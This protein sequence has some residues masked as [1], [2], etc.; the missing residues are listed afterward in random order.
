MNSHAGETVQV[1]VEQIKMVKIPQILSQNTCTASV[2]WELEISETSFHRGI[3]KQ[4]TINQ[5]GPLNERPFLSQASVINA[6]NKLLF[7]YLINNIS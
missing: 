1:F 6:C 7:S 5:K 3:K 4:K 2:A